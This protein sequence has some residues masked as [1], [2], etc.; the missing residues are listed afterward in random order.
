MSGP[1]CYR[2]YTFASGRC[3]TRENIPEQ[4]L[5]DP[6]VRM[7]S[8]LPDDTGRIVVHPPALLP[9]PEAEGG[10]LVDVSSSDTPLTL[11]SR[12]ALCAEN[13]PAAA[14]ARGRVARRSVLPTR[15]VSSGPTSKIWSCGPRAWACS[16][17]SNPLSDGVGKSRLYYEFIHSHRTRDWLVLESGSVSHGKAT[18]YLPLIDLLKN[19]FQIENADD[20]RRI[21]RAVAMQRRIA[22]A[23]FAVRAGDGR[24]QLLVRAD[25]A[26]TRIVAVSSAPPG[27]VR[28]SAP[29]PCNN[30]FWM[31]METPNVISSASSGFC[32]DIRCSRNRCSA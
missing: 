32:P 6:G 21:E 4:Q 24:V 12:L 25:G 19:Y 31:T 14:A 18:A 30:P 11:N 29:K 22:P 13:M 16:S 23:S 1:F 10:T 27:R 28:V 8:P 5:F 15:A 9:S 2:I 7:T 20:A 26:A 3:D 17:A